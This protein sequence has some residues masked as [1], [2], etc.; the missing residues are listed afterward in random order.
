MGE[1]IKD[2]CPIHIGSSELMIE[3]NEGWDSEERLIHVQN[4]KFRY[5]FKERVFF[6]IAGNVLRAW[7]KLNRN[8]SERAAVSYRQNRT[9]KNS[10][11]GIITEA[12][13]RSLKEFCSLVGKHDIDYRVIEAGEKFAS[14]VVFNDDYD[15]LKNLIRK[16]REITVLEHPHGRMFG[17]KFLYQMKPFELVKYKGIYI[18][19][20]F[21]LPC[22]S[23]TPKTWMPLEKKIQHRVWDNRK[24]EGGITHI[25]D[26][27]LLIFKICQAIFKNGYFTEETATLINRLMSVV[28][29][30]V[31]RMLL[32]EVFFLF[33]DRLLE[34][35]SRKRY[36]EI[37]YQYVTFCKY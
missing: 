24:A 26:T 13:K 33:T 7:L 28:D 23:L 31:L 14:V 25:D 36:D 12:S 22:M 15:R 8:R 20:V 17:Y 27:S 18:E 29:Q 4:K 30:D 5:Q 10:C 9:T 2:L 11:I 6:D 3:L 21:Q 34:M 35:I 1:K 32:K 19:V 16:D 37:V